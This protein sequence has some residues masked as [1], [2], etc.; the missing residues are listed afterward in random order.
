MVVLPITCKPRA[1]KIFIA[2]LRSFNTKTLSIKHC[3]EPVI[4]TQTHIRQAARVY[5][6]KCLPDPKT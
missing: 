3:S 2:T 5:I 6:D 1:S 4:V